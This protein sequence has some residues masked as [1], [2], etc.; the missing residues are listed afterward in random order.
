[1]E[2]DSGATTFWLDPSFGGAVFFQPSNILVKIDGYDDKF[3]K[4]GGVLL[5]V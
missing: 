5:C 3:A 1:V 2:E 4:K